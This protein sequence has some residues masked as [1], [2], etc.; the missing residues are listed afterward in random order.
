MS[1]TRRQFVGSMA[2]SVALG[3]YRPLL[4]QTPKKKEGPFI[5]GRVFEGHFVYG[6]DGAVVGGPVQ[7]GVEVAVDLPNEEHIRNFGAPRDGLGLCVFA[8]MTMAAKWHN[9]RGLMDLMYWDKDGKPHSKIPNGGGWPDKVA[10]TFQRYSPDT[11]FIQYLGADPA[12]LDKALSEGRMACVTYGYAERYRMQRIAHMVCLVYFDQ[13]WA[14]VLDN[15]FPGTY[16]WMSRGEFLKR[17][18]YPGNQG[19]AYVML[20]P[21]PPPIPHN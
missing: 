10:S 4:A 6:A 20:A 18:V 11:H 15:N 16:E 2:L 17:W 9:V 8:S 14:C 19:W 3:L 1:K 5:D 12:I 7:N 13:T 21:T